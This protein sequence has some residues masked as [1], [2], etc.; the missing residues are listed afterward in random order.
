MA[1]L[2]FLTEHRLAGALLILSFISFALGATIPLVGEKGN[3]GIFTLPLREY[4]LAVADNPIAWRWA[5]IFMG[6]AAVLL[7][8]GFTILTT[9]LEGAGERILSRLGL[10]GWLVAAV[11]WLIFSAF[12][13]VVT[14]QASA[15]MA[16]TGTVP[17]YYETLAQWGAALFY[18]YAVIGFL[19]LATY[20]GA[21]LRADI[22]P[23]WTGWAT[24]I[25]SVAVLVLMLV[26]GDTLPAFHYFPAL[27]IG[28]LLVLRR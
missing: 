5:N 18:A 25:F 16:G 3:A 2:D 26:Q 17:T 9:I 6:A 19:S 8:A 28:I 12:R 11:L 10:V 21:S 1:T 24:L 14:V 27:L 15:E 20:G 23:A 22:V 7:L 13:A 4:L